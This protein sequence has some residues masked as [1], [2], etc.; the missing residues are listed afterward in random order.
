M[1]FITR[2]KRTSG[3]T[4]TAADVIR[5]RRQAARGEFGRNGSISIR[6]VA[7]LYKMSVDAFRR[8]LRGDSWGWIPLEPADEVSPEITDEQKK[9]ASESIERVLEQVNAAKDEDLS[10]SEEARKRL[11]ELM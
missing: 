2:D 3:A 8:M 9:A 1:P 4:L 10:I 6:E 7:G 5:L 11:D